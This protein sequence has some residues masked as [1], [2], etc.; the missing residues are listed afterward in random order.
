MV[1]LALHWWMGVG[2]FWRGGCGLGAVGAGGGGVG[3][4]FHVVGLAT[5]LC[6]GVHRVLEEGGEN[7]MVVGGDRPM[8]RVSGVRG[9]VMGRIVWRGLAGRCLSEGRLEGRGRQRGA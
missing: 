3:L 2:F 5:C 1:C 7:D 6:S 4:H 9:L 8:W